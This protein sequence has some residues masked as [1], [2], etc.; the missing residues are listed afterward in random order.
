MSPNRLLLLYLPTQ[1]QRVI[2]LDYA[3]L[4]RTL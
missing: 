1:H 2:A 3:I 4:Y